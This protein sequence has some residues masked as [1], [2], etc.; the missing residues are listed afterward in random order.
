MKEKGKLQ[1]EVRGQFIEGRVGEKNQEWQRKVREDE[2]KAKGEGG[3]WDMDMGICSNGF[4]W[5][6]KAIRLVN[7]GWRV[8]AKPSHPS[9]YNWSPLVRTLWNQ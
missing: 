5:W 3:Q 4:V 7:V 2:E 8:E 9:N 6:E 1:R